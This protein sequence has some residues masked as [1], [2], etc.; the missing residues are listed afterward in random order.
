MAIT[1][2]H[3]AVCRYIAEATP[4]TVPTNPDFLLLSKE[5]QRVTIGLDKDGQ[6]SL[7]IGE[8]E[9]HDL[10]TVKNAYKLDVEF[11]LYD[12]TSIAAFLARQ[13]DNTLKSWAF[14]IIPNQDA[15]SP[16]YIR[17]SGWRCGSWRLGGGDGKPYTITLSFVGGTI[18][19]PTTTDPGL[20]TGSRE[21][22]A[23][24]D[25]RLSSPTLAV[26]SSGA[27]TVNGSAVAVLMDSF[28]LDV[29]FGAQA[30]Y[31]TGNADPVAA[32]VTAGVTKYTGSAS[33]SLDAGSKEHW[34]RVNAYAEHTIEVPF[35]TTTGDDILNLS[36]VRFPS[37]DVDI[38]VGT[39][40]LMANNPFQ[41]KSYSMTTVA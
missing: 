28:T 1:P 10:F 18:T 37:L 23:G 33:F 26:W 2:G 13:A 36:G 6:E 9:I 30:H 14:D 19:A 41:A 20:G 27:I 39:D 32:A 31:T 22:K 4:G 35:G 29:D 12:V 16:H 38:S 25:T 7:D 40:L 21:T 8:E 24:Y 3:Q 11:H 17:A 34:D 15:T 5:T